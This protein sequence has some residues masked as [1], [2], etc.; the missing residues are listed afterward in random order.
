MKTLSGYAEWFWLIAHTPPIKPVENRSWSLA[1][2]GIHRSDL[3]LRIYL[4]ASKKGASEDE[5]D[6]IVRN[7]TEEQYQ[8]F[9]DVE[10]DKLRGHIFAELTIIDEITADDIGIP[11]SRSPWFFGKFGFVVRDGKLLDSPIPYKGQLGFFEVK[12]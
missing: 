4:H 9:F 3:P 5:V 6:F 2:K 8:E 7:L 1:S 10:W 12:L 11:E